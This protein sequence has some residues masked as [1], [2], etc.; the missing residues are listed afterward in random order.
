MTISVPL[1]CSRPCR[2]AAADRYRTLLPGDSRL[3]I[4]AIG[5][6][7]VDSSPL[8]PLS[9]RG[10][11]YRF[12]PC[13]ATDSRTAA[14]RI[15]DGPLLRTSRSQDRG[16]VTLDC[17]FVD[18]CDRLGLER[19]IPDLKQ[20]NHQ[21]PLTENQVVACLWQ[22]SGRKRPISD[23]LR[24]AVGLSPMFSVRGRIRW[25]GWS[26]RLSRRLLA[27]RVRAGAARGRHAPGHDGQGVNSMRDNGPQL[28]LS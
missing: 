12:D 21:R 6:R 3:S 1:E 22:K 26:G 25:P 4:H 20:T 7:C 11:V 9:G 16:K 15:V 18:P 5:P 2:D 13:G 19:P 8:D 10:G 27:S 24:T 17:P 14:R 23:Q 28:A